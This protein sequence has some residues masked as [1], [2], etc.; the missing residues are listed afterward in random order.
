MTILIILFSIYVIENTVALL[1]TMVR[2][3]KYQDF[4]ERQ[5]EIL[6]AK[7]ARDRYIFDIQREDQIKKY[8]NNLKENVNA[9]K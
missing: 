9:E 5:L 1:Y 8:Y 2:D 3:E 4:M 7:E 6:E